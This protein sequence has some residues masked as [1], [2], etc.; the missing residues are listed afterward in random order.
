MKKYF[1]DFM[2]EIKDNEVV[3]YKYTGDDDDDGD[4]PSIFISIWEELMYHREAF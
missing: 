4:G 2:Y 3:I 1:M